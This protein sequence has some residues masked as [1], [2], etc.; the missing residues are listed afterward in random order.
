MVASL[1]CLSFPSKAKQTDAPTTHGLFSNF[2]MTYCSPASLG[3]CHSLSNYPVAS[4]LWGCQRR[5]VVCGEYVFIPRSLSTQEH[6][7][8]CLVSKASVGSSGKTVV[9]SCGSCSFSHDFCHHREQDL[10]YRI[11]HDHHVHT[12]RRWLCGQP[13]TQQCSRRAQAE[14]CGHVK[15]R[16][17]ASAVRALLVCFSSCVYC[18]APQ[19]CNKP[20]SFVPFL[21]LEERL[22]SST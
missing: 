2:F 18:E 12:G 22:Q 8:I 7:H 19:V 5:R 4:W 16:G 9:H 17:S 14:T 11:S 3:D 10:V 15:T 1:E 13:A 6:G 20:S 21:S